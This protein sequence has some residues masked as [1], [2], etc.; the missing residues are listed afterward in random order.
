MLAFIL[1]GIVVVPTLA[2]ALFIA[3]AG[4]MSDAPQDRG[5]SIWPV[6]VIGFGIA[7]LLVASHYIHLS[8]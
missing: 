6:F 5:P 1:A 4:G 8:W 7:A 3:F 2:I